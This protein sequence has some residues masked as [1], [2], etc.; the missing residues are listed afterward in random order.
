MLIVWLF[1]AFIMLCG[2][3]HFFSVWLGSA[4]IAMTVA[5]A[6]TYLCFNSVFVHAHLVTL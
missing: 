3:T 5:K 6:L 1:M 2:T 4:S